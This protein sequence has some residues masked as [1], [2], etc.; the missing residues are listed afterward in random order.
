LDAPFIQEIPTG[1][2]IWNFAKAASNGGDVITE[3][4]SNIRSK[5][6]YL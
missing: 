3:L 1:R 2:H 5:F 4:Q 6:E